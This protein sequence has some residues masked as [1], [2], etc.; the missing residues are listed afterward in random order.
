MCPG[1]L[2]P[3]TCPQ[4]ITVLGLG[5]AQNGLQ[6]VQGQAGLQLVRRQ[7]TTAA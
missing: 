5:P 3:D 6:L 2:G 1:Q 4:D 7:A